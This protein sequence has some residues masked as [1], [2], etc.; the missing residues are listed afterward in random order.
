MA[1]IENTSLNLSEFGLSNETSSPKQCLV[2]MSKVSIAVYVFT[3]LA[4][5]IA[6]SLL[7]SLCVRKKETWLLYVINMAVSDLLVAI[8]LLPRFIVNEIARS[9]DFL[10]HGPGG[11]FLCKMC[12][13]LSDISLSVST[14]TLVMIA[15]ER[16]VA[17]VHP[18]LHI[19]ISNSRKRRR[20]LIA[21]TWLLAA[22]FHLPYFYTFKLVRVAVGKGDYIQVCYSTWEPAFDDN[23][24]HVHYSIFLFTAVL[25]LPLL[26]I[27]VLYIAVAL[28]IYINSMRKFRLGR[29]SRKRQ[30]SA[31]NLLWMAVATVAAFLICWTMYII[32]A[33]INL[34]SPSVMLTCNKSYMIA[35]YIANL[36][37]SCYCAV[38]PW[39]CFI[40]I[41]GFS[42][43]LRAMIQNRKFI[44]SDARSGNRSSSQGSNKSNVT[45]LP[46]ESSMKQEVRERSEP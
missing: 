29:V 14:L 1:A 12:S 27:S 45:M 13:F 42:R 15:V 3:I 11:T 44:V 36:L 21:L 43:V 41:P 7:I 18:L 30:E 32:I 19:R 17:V 33:F 34:F 35:S 22:G 9:N 31:Q 8:F 16:F 38:N 23:T 2:G 46:L 24:G 39:L 5:L 20:L 6:N 40:F 25:I 26:V 37:A 4:S 10:V 28:R